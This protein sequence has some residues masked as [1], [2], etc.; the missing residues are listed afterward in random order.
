[1]RALCAAVVLAGTVTAWVAGRARA[2]LLALLKDVDGVLDGPP[3]AG[4]ARL[5]GSVPAAEL[6]RFGV[7]DGNLPGLVARYGLELW[8]VNGRHPERLAE[9][10]STGA[11]K[12]TRVAAGQGVARSDFS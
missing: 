3:A 4:G 5:R 11:T 1:M 9:L 8:L 10:L 12:G 6:G 2:P 7:V